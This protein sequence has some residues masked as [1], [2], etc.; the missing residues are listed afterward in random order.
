MTNDLD[1]SSEMFSRDMDSVAK[2]A[3]FQRHGDNEDERHQIFSLDDGTCLI[4]IVQV[5]FYGIT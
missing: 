2:E 4:I 3:R 1:V 5:L